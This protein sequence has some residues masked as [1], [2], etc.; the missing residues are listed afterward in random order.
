MDDRLLAHDLA[1]VP[2]SSFRSNHPKPSFEHAQ[3]E[4]PKTNPLSD[5]YKSRVLLSIDEQQ[6][7]EQYGPYLP[8][9]PK[10]KVASSAAAPGYTYAKTVERY[11]NK[12]VRPAESD[13]MMSVKKARFNPQPQ[14]KV[15]I[16]EEPVE[17]GLNETKSVKIIRVERTV[18]AVNNDTLKLARRMANE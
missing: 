15:V 18:P 3:N 6:Y 5:S 17:Q 11:M 14:E 4:S 2:S 8:S 10:S 1:L 12:K 16:L 9:T 13:E 7:Q